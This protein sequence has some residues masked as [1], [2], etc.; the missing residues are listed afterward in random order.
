MNIYQ[1]KSPCGQIV[2]FKTS[3]NVA[4]AIF[5]LTRAGTY[6]CKFSTTVKAAKNI[7]GHKGVGLTRAIKVA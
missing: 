5:V 1:A 7:W 2:E 6:Q 4:Y 3:R